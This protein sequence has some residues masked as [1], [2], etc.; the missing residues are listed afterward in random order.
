[1]I[2]PMTALAILF[3]LLVVGV[4]YAIAVITG[5]EPP[6]SLSEAFRQRLRFA[7]LFCGGTALA[8]LA[9]HGMAFERWHWEQM[10]AIIIGSPFAIFIDLIALRRRD[11]RTTI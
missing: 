3:F 10:V 11:K 8:N 2:D 9:W 7:A 1:M 4:P 5:Y 6:A